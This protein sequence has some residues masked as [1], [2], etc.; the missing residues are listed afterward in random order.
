MDIPNIKL[1]LTVY[2]HVTNNVQIYNIKIDNFLSFQ[3]AVWNLE[4]EFIPISCLI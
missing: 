2:I 1:N 3:N 4:K